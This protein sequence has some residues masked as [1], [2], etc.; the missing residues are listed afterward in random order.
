MR[1]LAC[2]PAGGLSIKLPV[3]SL[4]MQIGYAWEIEFIA[5]FPLNNLFLIEHYIA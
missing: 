4:A 2:C 3:Q 5:A 1:S